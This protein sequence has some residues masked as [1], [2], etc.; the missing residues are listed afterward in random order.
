MYS[1]Q[2][3][4]VLILFSQMT[5]KMAMFYVCSSNEDPTLA[6]II[7][8]FSFLFCAALTIFTTDISQVHMNS[9]SHFVLK[10]TT[11]ISKS[12]LSTPIDNRNTQINPFRNERCVQVSPLHSS[13]M[14]RWC[15]TY[16]RP[17]NGL[18]F[19][20]KSSSVTPMSCIE[21]AV[22]L[23]NCILLLH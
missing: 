18:F 1:N 10:Q 12:S 17:V 14:Q 4:S 15:F 11:G 13:S 22:Q 20:C 7:H 5:L 2:Q 16:N 3:D 21:E 9:L 23:D 8:S 6:R 19:C